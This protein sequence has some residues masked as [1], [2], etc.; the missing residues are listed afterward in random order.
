MCFV[1][2]F[3]V[4]VLRSDF[5]FSSSFCLRVASLEFLNRC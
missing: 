4:R 1:F 2:A 5:E 3:G